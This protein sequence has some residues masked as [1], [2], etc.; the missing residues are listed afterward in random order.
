MTVYID[1]EDVDA[2]AAEL[3]PQLD[4]LPAGDAQGP[5]G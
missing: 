5:E 1:V 3:R 2:L 4:T